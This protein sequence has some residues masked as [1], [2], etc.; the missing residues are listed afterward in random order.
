MK[1]SGGTCSLSSAV[2]IIDPKKVF[3]SLVMRYLYVKTV[4]F[5]LSLDSLG[6]IYQPNHWEKLI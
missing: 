6:E 3:N 5:K 2:S 4:Q 1:H